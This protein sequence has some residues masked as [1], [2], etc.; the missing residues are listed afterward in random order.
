MEQVTGRT[1]IAPGS[2]PKKSPRWR[3]PRWRPAQV[4]GQRCRASPVRGSA[5]AGTPGQQS[6]ASLPPHCPTCALTHICRHLARPRR[7]WEY[8]WH[9]CHCARRPCQRVRWFASI[10]RLFLIT[11]AI[12]CSPAPKRCRATNGRRLQ[13]HSSISD[14]EA[15]RSCGSPKM[16]SAVVQSVRPNCRYKCR[17]EPN[18]NC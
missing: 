9:R 10:P 11:K 8:C 3:R 4:I 18:K 16:R 14:G 13:Q 7:G 15:A 1:P 12:G 2:M 6:S 5:S 17:I